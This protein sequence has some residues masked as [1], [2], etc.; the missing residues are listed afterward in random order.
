MLL[1]AC[2]ISAF[3]TPL[4]STMMNLS[5]VGIG[6][7]FSVGSHDLAYV[8]TAFLLSSVVFMV[9]FAR[10]GDTHGKRRTSILGI[11]VILVACIL[12]SVAPSFWFLVACR[13]VMG[14]GAAAITCSSMSMIVDVFPIGSRGSA[15]GAQTTCVYSGLAIGPAVGGFL[16]DLFGW[17]SLFLLIVPLA[18]ASI[19]LFWRFP[20]EIAPDRGGGV[21]VP[22][23]ALYG[24][25]I[26]LTMVGVMNMPSPY[27]FAVLPVGLVLIV[28]FAV[29]QSRSTAPIL[30]V[31]LFRNRVF[32]A[33]CLA[34]F[35]SYAASYSVSFFMPLYLQHMGQLSSTEAGIMMLVQPAMQVL[36][37]PVAG[38]MSDRIRD[39]RLLPTLGMVLVG[40]GV[41]MIATYGTEPSLALVASTLVVIG[42]GHSL[43]SA[44]NT[45]V[46][47]SS[48]DGSHTGD[49][50]AMAGVMRQTGMMV[51]MGVSM[52]LI[53][54]VMGSADNIVPET[55]GS[56][57]D[58][59]TGTALLCLAMCA[60]GAVASAMRGGPGASEG[61]G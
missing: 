28:L 39:K 42:V 30:N 18:V 50:S 20:F 19:A 32:S 1:M 40:I 21:D 16:N 43:F 3:I 41:S 57:M 7:D 54:V 44:P 2:C 45:S 60:V 14:A 51:S 29:S 34:A 59:M 58:V 22:A 53:S 31:R 48:V 56:F 5:L 47:M 23:S 46:I 26:L 55:Y 35:L 38:R 17:H 33:S 8:N 52:L 11:S 24:S 13:A 49:A 9:P 36:L 4:L 61:K 37:T 15:I 10:Y 6:E 12:A 27:A 25:A